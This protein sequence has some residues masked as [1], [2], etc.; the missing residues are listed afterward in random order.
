MPQYPTIFWKKSS[1]TFIK[2]QFHCVFRKKII[3]LSNW[4]PTR[5]PSLKGKVANRRF[6]GR[7]LK[8]SPLWRRCWA[9]RS[10][11][12]VNP[13][14]KALIKRI[15][16][17]FSRMEKW[18]LQGTFLS[19]KFPAPS[20]ISLRPHIPCA[21]GNRLYNVYGNRYRIYGLKAMQRRFFCK[22]FEKI[23]LNNKTYNFF[24]KT[25]W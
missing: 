4:K 10:G 13:L 3:N 24:R 2:T 8:P 7:V 5:K 16:F 6:D 14:I 25:Q 11:W 22:V 21:S 12:V 23:N 19:Q 1:K 18:D 15:K 9:K 20:K 17:N